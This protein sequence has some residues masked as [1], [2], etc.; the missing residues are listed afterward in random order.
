[1]MGDC[2]QNNTDTL[3]LVSA[4]SDLVPP[5]EFIKK[6]HPNKKIKIFFPPKSFSYDLNNFMKANKGAITFLERSKIK[7]LNCIMPDIVTKD[8]ITYTIPPKWKL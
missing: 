1:M 8:N 4:D 7:F 2:E 3:I 6:Y 5:V